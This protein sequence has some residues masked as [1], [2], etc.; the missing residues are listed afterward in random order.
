M[1]CIQDVVQLYGTDNRYGDALIDPQ[2]W[3]LQQ[4]SELFSCNQDVKEIALRVATAI[5]LIIAT[6][7]AFILGLAGVALKAYSG[8]PGE[9]Q[10]D[11]PLPPQPQSQHQPLFPFSQPLRMPEPAPLPQPELPPQL[12][13]QQGESKA[14]IQWEPVQ[15]V[16]AEILEVEFTRELATASVP[17]GAFSKATGFRHRNR[18]TNVLPYNQTL[19]KHSAKSG[20]YF[21]AS[22]VMNGRA[23]ICQGPLPAEIGDF[24]E[25]IWDSKADSIVMVTDLV[26]SRNVKCAHYWPDLNKTVEYQAFGISVKCTSESIPEQKIVKRVFEITKERETRIITQLHFMNWIDQTGVEPA[27]LRNLVQR[28]RRERRDPKSPYICHCS[29]GLGRAST[30]VSLEEC[31]ERRANGN[32]NPKLVCTVVKELRSHATGRAPGAVQSIKQYE[33]IYRAFESIQSLDA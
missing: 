15:P 22:H 20:F 16:S 27:L 7:V 24:W 14:K 3:C 30:Y 11:L 4:W 19:F 13:S 25:M 21:N 33:A 23:I 32:R 17:S 26:E 5:V 12:Q 6:I 28:H 1:S 31:V 2:R 9:E 10:R 18:Y 8:A 29:A